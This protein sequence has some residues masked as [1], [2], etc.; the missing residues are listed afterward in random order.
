MPEYL[1]ILR[2]HDER[3]E[4][5]SS[6]QYQDVLAQFMAWNE[7]MKAQDELVDAG[8]LT[9]DLGLTVRSRD[10]KIALDGPFA[11][12]KEAIAGYYRVRC[13]DHESA[14]RIARGCP[15][16]TY[17]GSVEVRQIASLEAPK[18]CHDA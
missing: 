6:D 12:A 4:T 1:L 9:S 18:P 5:F 8:K 15:V 14:V 11:E 16:L 3:W 2:D 13:R 17:G 10:G 7:S